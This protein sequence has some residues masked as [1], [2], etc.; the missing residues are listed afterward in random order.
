[1][2]SITGV[3]LSFRPIEQKLHPYKVEQ[4]NT[5]TLAETL[6]VLQ[7]K[8]G[9]LTELNLDKNNFVSLEGFDEDGNDFKFT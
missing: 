5:I 6:P 1:M 2:T 7:N 4:F 3:I 9:D 8:Y